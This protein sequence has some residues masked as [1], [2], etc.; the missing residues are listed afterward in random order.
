MSEL[1]LFEIEVENISDAE[2][3]CLYPASLFQEIE[4]ELSQK[5]FNQENG[6]NS[7]DGPLDFIE[8]LVNNLQAEFDE[9][10]GESVDR[11]L[12]VRSLTKIFINIA[13]NTALKL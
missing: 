12:F 8:N 5:L 7:I 9:T 1:E 13:I 6:D 3:L 11:R 10:S 2:S 4:Q